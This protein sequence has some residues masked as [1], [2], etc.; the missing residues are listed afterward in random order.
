MRLRKRFLRARVKASLPIQFSQE[1]LTAHAGLS[2]IG[3][4][5]RASGWGKRIEEVF[6]DRDFDTDYWSFRMTL[7]VIGLLL[8]GGT[9]LAH[10]RELEIDPVFLRFARLVQLPSERT[11]SRWL[12]DISEGYRDRLRDLLRDIAFSTWAHAKLRRVTI[13]LDGTSR[14]APVPRSKEPSTAST[15]IIRRIRRTIR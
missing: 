3:D 11:V 10:L 2:V 1:P 14:S 5:F 13:D 6:F 9:R 15:R 4:F 7:S 12:K 8:V